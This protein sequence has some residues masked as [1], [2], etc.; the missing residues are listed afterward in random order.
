M[1][2]YHSTAVLCFVF[3]IT[4]H[5]FCFYNNQSLHMKVWSRNVRFSISVYGR[6]RQCQDLTKQL[7][8]A[9]MHDTSRVFY[10][11]QIMEQ[12]LHPDWDGVWSEKAPPS[13]VELPERFVDISRTVLKPDLH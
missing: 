12:R 6:S 11:L 9:V 8:H 2:L 1:L 10:S 5:F 4:T 7:A 3:L 13:C